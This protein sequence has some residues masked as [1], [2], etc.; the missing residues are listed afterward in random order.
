MLTVATIYILVAIA[1]LCL[2]EMAIKVIFWE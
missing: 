1:V 2:V